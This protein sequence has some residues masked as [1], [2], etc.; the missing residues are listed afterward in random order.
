MKYKD[1]EIILLIFISATFLFPGI[2]QAD[3]IKDDFQVNEEDYPST[4]SQST[5]WVARDSSGNFVVVWVDN[6]DADWDIRG[7]LYSSAGV[8]LGLS[9]KI[10]DDGGMYMQGSPTVACDKYGNFVVAWEDQRNGGFDIYAQRFDANGNP[11]GAN[12]TPHPGVLYNQF[13]PTIGM[14]PD[15]DFVIAWMDYR[16]Y[17]ILSDQIYID[18]YAQRYDA[19][20]TPQDTNFW[21]NDMDSI[22]CGNPSAAMASSGRFIITWYDNRIGSDIFAQFYDASGAPVGGNLYV[23]DPQALTGQ[24]YPSVCVDGRGYITFAWQDYRSGVLNA[25]IYAARYDSLCNKL[26]FDFLVD[27][28]PTGDDQDWPRIAAS[29]GSCDFA[30]TW[31]DQRNGNNDIYARC[32]DSLGVAAG[33]NFRVDDDPGTTDQMRASVSLDFS[34]AP[35]YVWQ[36]KRNLHWDIYARLYDSLGVVLGPGFKI[37]DD[38][39]GANQTESELACCESTWVVVW[40]DGRNS[41]SDIYGQ[42]FDTL[43]NF[44]NTN[45]LINDDGGTSSQSIPKVGMS[46]SGSFV[47]VWKDYRRG[48]TMPDIYCQRFS[49]SGTPLGP[50]FQVNGANMGSQTYGIT[51]GVNR[52]G[53]FAIGW[54]RDDSLHF[55]DQNGNLINRAQITGSGWIT[56]IGDI[57]TNYAGDFIVLFHDQTPPPLMQDS[58]YVQKYDSL[59]NAIGGSIN[60]SL[61]FYLINLMSFRIAG[62]SAGNFAITWEQYTTGNDIWARVYDFN[63]NPISDTI[64]FSG[65]CTGPEIDMAPHGRFTIAWN[66][67]LDIHAQKFLADGSR[68][69]SDFRIS[70]TSFR[71]QGGPSVGMTDS[72]IFFSWTDSRILGH[73]NDIFAKIFGP[74]P[75]GVESYRCQIRDTRMDILPTLSNNKFKI[76]CSGD[77]G[78]IRIYNAL[79]NFVKVLESSETVV[80]D[81]TDKHGCNLPSGVYFIHFVS[82][83]RREIKKVLLIK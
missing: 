15:G 13:V 72:L 2:S 68:D 71:Y 47:A 28:D 75:V 57:T 82:K 81:G 16:N 33:A 65:N 48:L 61:P 1:S 17:P 78:S 6:R 63:C 3:V 41:N 9:F 56:G 24:Y 54:T 29:L 59:G 69:G 12:F 44:L 62:D 8:P 60:L 22:N 64:R 5:P 36:D 55:Y 10:N 52:T 74:G 11:L 21:V 37:N 27:D 23:T 38:T 53:K 4:F 79:G 26:D 18:I 39:I 80:W 43:G 83:E 67:S 40:T 25:D 7:R 50:N 66:Q 31:W 49:P 46:A 34:G 77:R 30:I 35:V 73:G 76:T 19:S 58:F 20:G 42:R 45:F 70:N 32:Y 14:S 51:I